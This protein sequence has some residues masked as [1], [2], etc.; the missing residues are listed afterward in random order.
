LADRF[1]FV[2][3]KKK[4]EYLLTNYINVETVCHIF[5]YANAFN[6]E[7]LRE[8]CLLFTEENY[9]DVIDSAGFEELDKEEIL[10]IIRVKKDKKISKK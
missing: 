9:N 7:L 1:D 6:C 8:S 10:K 3:F 4:C 2:S 5:K